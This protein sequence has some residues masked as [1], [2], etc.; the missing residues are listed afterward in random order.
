MRD[1]RV[2][3][4]L[5]W[6]GAADAPRD[7]TNERPL[8]RF[9]IFQHQWSARVTLTGVLATF[10]KAGTDEDVG[11]VLDEAGL[12]V[13][14][15]AL[16]VGNNGHADLLHDVRKGPIFVQTSPSGDNSTATNEAVVGV[17]YA[18]WYHVV[19]E[20]HGLVEAQQ[21]QVVLEGAGIEARVRGHDLHAPLHVRQ[22]LT[23]T[24][25]VVL[26]QPEKDVS[27]RHVVNTV[28]RAD[29]PIFVE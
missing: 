29:G 17:G 4:G 11:D 25:Q 16:F 22:W 9:R 28:G 3:A 24:L 23:L 27:G 2:H 10:G 13:H 26:A 21:S 20:G 18:D 1:P 15:L 6:Q 7:D 19:L 12:A 8:P 5:I 14:A